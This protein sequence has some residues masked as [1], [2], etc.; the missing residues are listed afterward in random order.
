MLRSS[1][2]A[3]AAAKQIQSAVIFGGGDAAQQNIRALL[4]QGVNVAVVAL[5]HALQDSSVPPA[6][7][8]EASGGTAPDQR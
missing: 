8:A 5:P 3:Q 7:A 1:R 2:V 4:A 6:T